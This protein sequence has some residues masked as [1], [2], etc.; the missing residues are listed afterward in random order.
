MGGRSGNSSAARAER[1]R[2]LREGQDAQF[3]LGTLLVSS[4]AP[5]RRG[6]VRSRLAL[7]DLPRA[8]RRGGSVKMNRKSPRTASFENKTMKF[9]VS[10]AVK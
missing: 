6:A 2:W 7:G 1:C 5:N 9:S 8:A 3:G 10:E 4:L